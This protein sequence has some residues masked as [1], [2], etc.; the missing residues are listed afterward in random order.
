[1]EFADP[2]IAKLVIGS[3]ANRGVVA[4]YTL[5][6]ANVIRLEPPLIIEKEQLDYVVSAFRSSLA[7]ARQLLTLLSD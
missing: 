5:N 1:V 7:D 3:L 6:N 2:D 4:A